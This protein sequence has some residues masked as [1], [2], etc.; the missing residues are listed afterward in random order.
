MNAIYQTYRYTEIKAWI[1]ALCFNK[2]NIKPGAISRKKT[3]FKAVV[4]ISSKQSL[5]IDK[6][7]INLKKTLTFRKLFKFAYFFKHCPINASLYINIKM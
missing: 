3:Y 4:Q 5:V 2:Y 7:I 6:K 1:Y